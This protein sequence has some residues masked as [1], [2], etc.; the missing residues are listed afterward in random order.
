MVATAEITQET[1]LET[2]R[3]AGQLFLIIIQMEI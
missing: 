1:V 3:L 2:H